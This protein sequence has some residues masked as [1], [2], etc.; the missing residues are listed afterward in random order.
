MKI[1]SKTVLK[2][3][4]C[5]HAE[6]NCS[7][8][9]LRREF[10]RFHELWSSSAEQTIDSLVGKMEP[11]TCSVP[12]V[13]MGYSNKIQLRL[14][15]R[16]YL[17]FVRTQK[18]RYKQHC[19]KFFHISTQ[20]LQLQAIQLRLH[21]IHVSRSWRRC[22]DCKYPHPTHCEYFFPLTVPVSLFFFDQD[23]CRFQK[24]WQNQIKGSCEP[25]RECR[26][27]LSNWN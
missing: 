1:L 19:T 13:I 17:L 2:S 16:Y 4:K 7:A 20:P 21:L 18:L 6:L 5:F 24:S 22:R 3:C 27:H 15:H 12:N 23:G 8:Y 26:W 10:H 11:E 25:T 9:L 14:P